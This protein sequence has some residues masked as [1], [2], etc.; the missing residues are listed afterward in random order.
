MS[1][2]VV[3]RRVEQ[4]KSMVTRSLVIWGF[5]LNSGENRRVSAAS[6]SFC[7]QFLFCCNILKR[8]S[9]VTFPLIFIFIFTASNRHKNHLCR[10]LTPSLIL[11]FK[12]PLLCSDRATFR[13]SHQL[14]Y[15]FLNHFVTDV[16][17]KMCQ[18]KWS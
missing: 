8:L 7:P 3:F 18:D 17:I 2:N 12:T 15:S 14:N 4:Q 1:E 13:I 9:N 11:T 5:C 16:L 6:C 10:I